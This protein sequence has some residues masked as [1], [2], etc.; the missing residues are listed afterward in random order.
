MDKETF[1]EINHLLRRL[2]YLVNENKFHCPRALR[3]QYTVPLFDPE[4]YSDIA[5]MNYKIESGDI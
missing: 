4:N 5:K 1:E 2:E 3:A